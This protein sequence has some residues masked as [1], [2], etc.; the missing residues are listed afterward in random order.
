VIHARNAAASAPGIDLLVT[1]NQEHAH[2]GETAL[3]IGNFDGVHLGHR[4]LVEQCRSRVGPEGKVV[5]LA[6]NPHPM[7][8]LNPEHAPEPIESFAERADRLI[9][10]GVDRVVELAPTPELL[11]K[12]PQAFVDELIDAYRPG[13]IVEGHDF[14]F[15]KRR[16]GTPVVLRELAGL[17]GVEVD[18]VRPVEVALTDQSV[19]I[20]SS[21]ITRWLLGNGRV[22]DAA[23]VLGRPHEL[24]GEVVRG[25]QLGRT[26][27]FRT[28][29]VAT[30]SML[31]RDG[32][33]AAVVTM[34]CG[35]R[36]GGAVNVG[37]RPTVQGTHRRAEVHLIDRDGAPMA[38]PEGADEY[39]W[40]I[41]VG[42][43]GWVRDQVRFDGVETLS[44]QLARD[45]KRAAAMV[46]ALLRGESVGASV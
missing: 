7:A 30:D 1:S 36:V 34:P 31:P 2:L 28:A 44:G 37:A 18:I 39:G 11:G 46:E 33:Y 3:T 35:T 42:L 38:L 17:R 9:R 13:V 23:F 24:A 6:F 21:T 8:Q 26:I 16:A 32:V 15:G 29:N 22:R 10:L 20:A 5:A 40:K 19:V 12:S 25:D 4:A 14:H 45:V 27:G 41:R 43:V